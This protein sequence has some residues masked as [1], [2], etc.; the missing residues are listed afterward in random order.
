MTWQLRRAGVADLEAIMAIENPVFGSDAWSRQAMRSELLSPHTYYLVAQALAAPEQIEAYAGIASPQGAP[1]ADIQTIAVLESA[2]R[3]GVARTLMQSLIA[4]A[5]DRGA[6]EV[7]L[8]V[9]A[10]NPGAQQLYTLL[11]FEQIAVRE[12][13]YQPD[14][15]DANIMRLTI[16][17]PRPH[18]SEPK[19]GPA[20]GQ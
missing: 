18:F 16:T 5:R 12:G 15:V 2:R 19:P 4:E 6:E 14:G 7:F 9:R 17:E 3:Q 13:Y 8:E 11:S 20:V 10:D 1:Q